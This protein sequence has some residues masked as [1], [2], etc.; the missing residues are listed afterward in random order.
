MDSSSLI[1]Q[2]P[3]ECFQR[4]KHQC[5]IKV[6]TDEQKAE[7]EKWHCP[8]APRLKPRNTD[9]LGFIEHTYDADR[10]PKFNSSKNF[11]AMENLVKY[12]PFFYSDSGESSESEIDE[13]S[14]DW[15]NELKQ[16]KSQQ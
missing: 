11:L 6:E 5:E 4:E 15:D 8:H 10:K 3:S 2:P 12:S 14:N 16:R 7:K 1:S 9:F 13:T